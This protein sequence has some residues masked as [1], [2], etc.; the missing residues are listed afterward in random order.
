MDV[1]QTNIAIWLG[2][3]NNGSRLFSDQ[4]VKFSKIIILSALILGSNATFAQTKGYDVFVPI[5]KYIR[6]GDA[7]KLSAWFADNLEIGIIAKP[8]DSSKNQAKQIVKT[9]FNAY[10]PH[11]FDITHNAGRSN[12]KYALGLLNA[13]GERFAVTIFVSYKTESFKIEQLKIEKIE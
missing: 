1:Q 13:G 3:C 2:I 4:M 11:T 9:F 10:T 8:S 6:C 5:A 12:M 7:D